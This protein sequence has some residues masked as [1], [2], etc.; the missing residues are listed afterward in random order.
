MLDAHPQIIVSKLFTKL[1]LAKT[2]QDLNYAFQSNSSA[3]ILSLSVS[4]IR[5][6]NITIVLIEAP[7]ADV[8][9]VAEVVVVVA[10]VVAAVVSVIAVA[11]VLL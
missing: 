1:L 4:S 2:A 10:V 9:V 5:Y 8:V 6:S 7:I 3:T 11:L